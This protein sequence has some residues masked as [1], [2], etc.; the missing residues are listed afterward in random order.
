[1]TICNL[2]CLLHVRYSG[3]AAILHSS[4]T[5]A[6]K[7]KNRALDDDDGSLIARMYEEALL[8]YK[9]LYPDHH[10]S[11]ELTVNLLTSVLTQQM[12]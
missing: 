1:M 8:I 5:V 3:L 11:V 10:F 12:K 6:N 9:S 7:S 2:T 4:L